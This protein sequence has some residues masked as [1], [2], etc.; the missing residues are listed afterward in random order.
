MPKDEKKRRKLNRVVDEEPSVGQILNYRFIKPYIRNKRVLDVGC[1]SGQIEKLAIKDVREISGIDPGQQ[2]IEF[3][4][5]EV[6]RAHFKLATIDNIPFKNNSFEVV[7]LLEVLE[8]IP[9][10]T[11]LAGL[12]EINRVLKKDGYL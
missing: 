8:H 10:G 7:L 5:K 2:A 11:E 4:K 6:P 9:K 3:A 12:K 1:W